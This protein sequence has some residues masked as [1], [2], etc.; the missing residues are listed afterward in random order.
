M[1][2]AIIVLANLMD[3][4]GKLNDESTARIT[5]ACELLQ[6]N[7]GALLIPCG[8]A[9]RD[10]S[11]ICIADAMK[12]FAVR[13]L[14][15]P[16]DFIFP[17]RA[18]RD[19]VGDAVFTKRHFANP[20]GWT[21]IVVVTSAYHAERTKQIFSFV[22]GWPIIVF[23]APSPDTV[24][25]RAAEARSSRAFRTTFDGIKAGDDEGIWER[26]RTRHP[27]YNGEVYPVIPFYPQVP[28]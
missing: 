8:W 4:S 14:G 1:P 17:V 23:A 2:E 9:Y 16:G 25:L 15:I 5:F 19:T 26:L 18:S 28:Q 10:D 22:Y 7:E 24:V 12:S 13:S 6:E 3:S 27:F 21:D 20:H 11:D